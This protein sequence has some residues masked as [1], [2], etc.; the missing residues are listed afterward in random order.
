MDVV[1]RDLI[2]NESPLAHLKARWV[3]KYVTITINID[4]QICRHKASQGRN[5]YY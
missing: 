2:D 3:K 4:Q 5:D 1:Y